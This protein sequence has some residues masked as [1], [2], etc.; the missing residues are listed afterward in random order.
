MRNQD[1]WKKNIQNLVVISLTRRSGKILSPKEVYE[2]IK[3]M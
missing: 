1:I 2:Q 3:D